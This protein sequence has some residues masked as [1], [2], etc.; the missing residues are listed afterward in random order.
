[1]YLLEF[2]RNNSKY[3]PEAL[4]FAKELD[5][6][7]EEN[8]VRISITDVLG[9]Y[10]Q[11][12]TLFA[13]IQDWKGTLATYNGSPVHP[14]QFLLSAHNVKV[15]SLER[16]IDN[17]CGPAWG[18]LK[19]DNLL[20]NVRG[21]PFQKRKFW[22]NYGSFSGYKWL[23]DKPAIYKVL[24]AYAKEKAIDA[25]PFFS[26]EKLKLSV[27]H[28]PDFLVPDNQTFKIVYKEKYIDGQLLEVPENITHLTSLSRV[29][30]LN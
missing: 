22:Y 20:Y 23:I 14:Y 2:R 24:R 4:K 9:A 30:S 21:R 29:T 6:T 28:L 11:I 10:S 18:C 8:R 3:F 27:K 15:C 5:G 16:E 19:I 12:R 7:L 17:T 26:E 25:C 13:I 1:M